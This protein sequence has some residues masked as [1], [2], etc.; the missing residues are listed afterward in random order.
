MER[1]RVRCCV[2][3]SVVPITV[4]WAVGDTCPCCSQP[5]QAARRRPKPEAM[6]GKAL[7]LPDAES[8]ANLVDP[9]AAKR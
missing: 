6:V 2:C 8:P 9:G 4:L 7:G 1:A 5:L 3:R